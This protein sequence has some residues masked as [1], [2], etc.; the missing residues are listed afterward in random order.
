[1]GRFVSD[2][3]ARSPD[4]LRLKSG[5]S[6][7]QTRFALSHFC[8]SNLGSDGQHFAEALEFCVDTSLLQQALDAISDEVRSRYPDR[9]LGLIACV[10]EANATDADAA[11]PVPP[12]SVAAT[13]AAAPADVAPRRPA[14]TQ[15]PQDAAEPLRLVAGVSLAQ[16]RFA[17]SEF[18]LDQFGPRAQPLLEAI[19]RCRDLGSLQKLLSQIAAEVEGRRR[20]SLPKLLE[21]VREINETSL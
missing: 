4:E 19:D 13:A 2:S 5:V 10:R 21:C 18:C 3:K 7:T 14:P 11:A 15:K 16:A 6:L 20:D 17:L 1:M 12:S 9:L 8:L